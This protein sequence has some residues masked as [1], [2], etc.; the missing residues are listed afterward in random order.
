MAQLGLSW[1]LQQQC[2][3]AKHMLAIPVQG[4]LEQEDHWAC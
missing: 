4:K 3:K 1:D 2:K